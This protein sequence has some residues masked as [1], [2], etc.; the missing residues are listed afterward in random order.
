MARIFAD[1]EVL[2]TLLLTY[3]FWPFGQER[4]NIDA[5]HEEGA[6][7][8]EFLY[9]QQSALSAPSACSALRLCG[10]C[11]SEL[12]FRADAALDGLVEDRLGR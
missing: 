8:T 1:L 12:E 3:K 6:E 7:N 11:A 10:C 4:Q 2:H 5:E 9:L